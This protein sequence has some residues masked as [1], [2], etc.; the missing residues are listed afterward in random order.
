MSKGTHPDRYLAPG[1]A[2]TGM[3]SELVVANTPMSELLHA[4]TEGRVT[5]L[6]LTEAYLARIGKYDSAGLALNSV[7][8]TNPNALAIAGR[9][10]H[11]KPS[12]ARPLAGMPILVKDNIA[13]GDEL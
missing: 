7:R 9:L 6:A 4:L 12:A 5:P 10:G 8:A 3:P 11:T 2:K 13:T 1:A